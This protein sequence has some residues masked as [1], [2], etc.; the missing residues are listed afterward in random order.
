M[1]DVG[2]S[3]AEQTHLIYPT[4]GTVVTTFD[5]TALT[6]ILTVSA[7]RFSLPCLFQRIPLLLYLF[8]SDRR[9]HA[10]V[11]LST[12]DRLGHVFKEKLWQHLIRACS[13]EGH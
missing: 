13:L 7:S 4:K 12:R 1:H 10:S 9:D 6:K 8:V 5:C 11:R 2:R 3:E